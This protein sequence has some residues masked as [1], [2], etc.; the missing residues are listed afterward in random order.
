MAP[1]VG[2]DLKIKFQAWLL[3][4]LRNLDKQVARREF[5]NCVNFFKYFLDLLK[6]EKNRT[7]SFLIVL[8]KQIQKNISDMPNMH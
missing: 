4:T 6:F 3:V 7:F 2:L 5:V 1:N 8:S